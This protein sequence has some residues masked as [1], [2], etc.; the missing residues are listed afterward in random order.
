V[1]NDII[2]CTINSQY[3][4]VGQKNLACLSRLGYVGSRNIYLVEIM[5][6]LHGVIL[7]TSQLPISA[8]V[9]KMH[10]NDITMKKYVKTNKSIVKYFKILSSST[11]AILS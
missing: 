2:T 6:N 7:A 9:Q 11:T 10:I 1:I 3:G 4:I 8:R 5:Q